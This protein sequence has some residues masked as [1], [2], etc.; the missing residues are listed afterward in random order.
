MR[1]DMPRC[2]LLLLLFILPPSLSAQDKKKDAAPKLLY[3]VPL[4]ATPGEKQKLVLRGQKLTDVTEVKVTGA[5]GAKLKLLGTRAVGVSNNYP[6]ARMGASEIEIE[7]EL[8]K[9]VKP[10]QVKLVATSAAGASNP[11]T[12]L[13]R[14]TIPATSEK[15][16]NDGFAQAQQ[17][18]LPAAIEGTIKSE[19]DVDLFQFVGKKGDKVRIGVEAARYGSPLDAFVTLYNS[20]R[21]VIGSADDSSSKADPVIIVTLPEDGA[22][23]ISIIDANDLGG[24][25]FG[26]RLVVRKG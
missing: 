17:I 1:H 3:A 23:F 15:E 24:A 5:D 21:A 6:E 11:Y 26:Y 8:P 12:L 2:S 25:Q 16:P 22:Y 19:R 13:V 20:R 9:N 10:G 4:V 7:L 14:D 18:P